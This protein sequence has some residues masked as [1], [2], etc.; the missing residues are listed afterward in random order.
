MQ[1]L[2][3][4]GMAFVE[5]DGEIT[6]ID[7]GPGESIQAETGAVGMFEETVSMNIEMVKG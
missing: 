4:N 5:L 3:G 2:S 1:R 6:E 7:L